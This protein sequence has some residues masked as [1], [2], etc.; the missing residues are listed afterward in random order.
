MYGTI[1]NQ[2]CVRYYLRIIFRTLV[3]NYRVKYSKKRQIDVM[4]EYFIRKNLKNKFQIP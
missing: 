4:I 2:M 1:V 3:I